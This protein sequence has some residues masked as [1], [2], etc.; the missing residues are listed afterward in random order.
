MLRFVADDENAVARDADRF[1]LVVVAGLL[2]QRWARRT[3]LGLVP[4]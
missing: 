3:R 1:G 4:A 2:L